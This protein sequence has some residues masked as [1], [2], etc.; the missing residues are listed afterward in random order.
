MKRTYR[1]L[2][3]LFFAA[4]VAGVAAA[5][6]HF[7]GWSL[8][9]DIAVA[10]DKVAGE[11]KS[12]EVCMV[13]DRVFGKPQIPVEYDGKTYYGCCQGCVSRIKNEPRVRYS[14]DPVSGKT[15]DKAKAVI[16]EGPGGQALYFESR[17]TAQKFV[18]DR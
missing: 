10:E 2:M 7:A 15:V 5:G 14:V 9:V 11:A 13:T 17:E 8:G 12:D 6:A 16:I 1:F 18:S 3:I 4:T